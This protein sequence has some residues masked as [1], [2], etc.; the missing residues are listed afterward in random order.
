MTNNTRTEVSDMPLFLVGLGAWIVSSSAA[1]IACFQLVY[2]IAQASVETHGST[3]MRELVL[4][5]GGIAA[6]WRI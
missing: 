5:V 3:S 6:Q 1:G 2:R 4:L